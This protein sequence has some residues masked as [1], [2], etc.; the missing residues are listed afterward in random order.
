M[1]I[2]VDC[3]IF[4]K[5]NQEIEVTQEEYKEIQDYLDNEG[6]DISAYIKVGNF[7]CRGDN[8]AF[9]TIFSALDLSDPYDWNDELENVEIQ[10]VRR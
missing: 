6:D 7:G 10:I 2:N 4:V 1:K 8:P 5:Y 9:Q 3:G